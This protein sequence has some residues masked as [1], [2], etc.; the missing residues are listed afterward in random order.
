MHVRYIL[1]TF[2]ILWLIV[3]WVHLFL[4]QAHFFLF[5]SYG[6]LFLI[7]IMTL[8]LTC[9]KFSTSSS[10][11]TRLKNLIS[12]FLIY[13]STLT[14]WLLWPATYLWMLTEARKQTDMAS[15]QT[16]R[17]I[18]RKEVENPSNFVRIISQTIVHVEQVSKS[19]VHKFLASNARIVLMWAKTK[20]YLRKRH[21]E[22][23]CKWSQL[24][25]Q[26][27]H[28]LQN[29]MWTDKKHFH[30]DRIEYYI[31]FGMKYDV[32]NQKGFHVGYYDLCGVIGCRPYYIL[33]IKE[34]LTTLK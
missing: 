30:L 9:V 11:I 34:T 17:R 2:L 1:Q 21:E 16:G 8:V 22:A 23:R 5:T 12:L 13:P 3:Q 25:V 31:L 10:L 7:I 20:P 32:K 29:V 6:L 15:S 27:R 24:S 28:N 4:I 18:V 26:E 19:Y 33:I 14:L